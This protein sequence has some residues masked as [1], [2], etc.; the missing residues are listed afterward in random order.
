VCDALSVKLAPLAS[1]SHLT[2]FFFIMSHRSQAETGPDAFKRNARI[3]LREKT[4]MRGTSG[5]D[6]GKTV[7]WVML[8]ILT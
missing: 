7:D 8:T 2:R 1:P 3:G 4:C 5:S 6:V